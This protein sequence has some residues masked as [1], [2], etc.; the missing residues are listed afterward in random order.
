MLRQTEAEKTL[1]YT[2]RIAYEDIKATNSA[3]S[4]RMLLH[5]SSLTMPP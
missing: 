5:Q 2:K 1:E 3:A 4:Q